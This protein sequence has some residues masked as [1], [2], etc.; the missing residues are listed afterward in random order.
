MIGLNAVAGSDPI[1][2]HSLGKLGSARHV[3][4]SLAVDQNGRC[5]ATARLTACLTAHA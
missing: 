4:R 2:L 3:L 5:F 1:D